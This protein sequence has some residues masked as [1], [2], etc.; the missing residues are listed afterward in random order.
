MLFRSVGDPAIDPLL[1]PVTESQEWQTL[2]KALGKSQSQL[3]SISFE[4]VVP[5]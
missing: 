1:G 5:N 4:V 2:M 3:D